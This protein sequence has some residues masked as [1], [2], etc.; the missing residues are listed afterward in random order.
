[1]YST[2]SATLS[3]RGTSSRYSPSVMVT[4]TP[5]PLGSHHVKKGDL[6]GEGERMCKSV[7]DSSRQKWW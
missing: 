7:T 6:L 3:M 1:M 2:L 4:C 5:P